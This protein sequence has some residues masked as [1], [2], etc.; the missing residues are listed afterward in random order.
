M[1]LADVFSITLSIVGFLLSLQGL[2]MISRALWPARVRNASLRVH[3]NSLASF[4]LG[5]LIIV[6]VMV[7]AIVVSK[8]AGAPGQF[9][10]FAL[11]SLFVLYA[12]VGVAGLVTHIGQRLPSPADSDRPWRATVRG[13]VALELAYL[14]PIV[15]WFGLLPI[16]F[17]LGAG[18][19][20][21]AFFTLPETAPV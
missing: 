21:L 17:I 9:F 6:V 11:G 3:R 8:R 19:N 12:N 7:L 10:G 14:V 15:G 18:A 20:T 2:W 16:S 13:G 4:F 1:L 5:L